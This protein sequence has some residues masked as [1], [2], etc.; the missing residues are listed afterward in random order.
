MQYFYKMPN[1]TAMLHATVAEPR[2]KALL[3]RFCMT[4]ILALILLDGDGR[5]ICTDACICLAVDPTSLGFP[6]QAPAG[7]R[8]LTPTVDFAV[9]PAKAPSAVSDQAPSQPAPHRHKSAWALPPGALHPHRPTRPPDGGWPPSFPEDK[10]K[11]A[12]HDRVA[13]NQDL[14]Q[15]A[16]ERDGAPRAPAVAADVVD[17]IPQAPAG[18]HARAQT[19]RETKRKSPPDIVDA[20][21]PPKEPNRV[22]TRVVP[23][24]YPKAMQGVCNRKRAQKNS[25]F[26]P[27]SLAR[28]KPENI[29]QGEHTLLM[30]PQPLA[31]VHLFM[32]T[33]KEWWHGIP[34]D[35]GPE[36]NWDVIMS[37]ANHGLHPTAQTQDSIALFE[38]DIEY[39]VKAGFCKVYLWEDLQK[40]RP[41]NLKISPV[42]V[43]PQVG[44][45]GRIILDLLFLVYQELNGIV[46]IT[47]ESINDTTVLQAP[48]ALV[49]EI[50]RVLPRLLH[51]MQDTPAG[52]HI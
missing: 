5:E 24:I 43:V 11:V 2:G 9:G 23:T 16:F 6:W 46:T 3:A 21:R 27:R 47:Q 35:C 20:G 39:Q 49:K 7:A 18:V 52:L 37:A 8:R 15:R 40:L 10:H 33:L 48:S 26:V 25:N 13:I 12:W 32:P 34:V 19:C 30:Q 28:P 51:Y 14:A 31:K 29:P 42:A 4:T 36:W 50:G 44:R 45:H 41:A 22:A 38:E 1:W 17:N